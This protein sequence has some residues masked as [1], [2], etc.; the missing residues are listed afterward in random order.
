[1]QLFS[2]A[3]FEENGISAELNIRCVVT[4]RR[5]LLLQNFMPLLC[6]KSGRYDKA[7]TD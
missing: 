6:T 4:I 1:M 2:R 7:K 3:L 5:L